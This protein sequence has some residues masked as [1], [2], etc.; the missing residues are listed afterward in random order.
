M[1]VRLEKKMKIIMCE[2]CYP[3]TQG[4]LESHE[5]DVT[6]MMN[7]L[8]WLMHDSI[9]HTVGSW[10]F[11][12]YILPVISQPVSQ[13]KSQF[14]QTIIVNHSIID[15]SI[16]KFI[17]IHWLIKLASI[18]LKLLKQNRIYAKWIY[19]FFFQLTSF[20]G[21]KIGNW[22]SRPSPSTTLSDRSNAN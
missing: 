2:S 3:L 7:I 16:C 8:F 5:F 20:T 14:N 4:I 10:G 15:R 12:Q 17:V 22:R 11:H 6:L 13:S 9:I 21:W 1:P 18:L 19:N